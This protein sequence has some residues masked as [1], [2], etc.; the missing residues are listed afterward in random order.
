[1]SEAEL[2]VFLV[3]D[4]EDIRRTL[5][6]A[7]KRR[8]FEVEA[9]ASAQEFLDAFEPDRPGCLVLDYGMPGMTGL[10][11]QDHLNEAG[12]TIP[13]I[14]ITG[15][16]G[17]PESVRAIR[18][19][20]VDFLEKPFR[21]S[22]LIEQIQAA[23]DMSLAQ[24]QESGDRAAA[25]QRFDRLT[26]REREIA[27]ILVTQPSDASSKHIARALD[28]SPRTV[29]HHR[30]RILEKMDVRSVAELVHLANKSELFAK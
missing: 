18:S 1:M 28:I 24:S 3:D 19:G 23:F 30:A 17:V 9:F 8:G 12:A 10:E 22:V 16:G 5:S 15:H 27:Q 14:F 21:Q 6:R 13:I 25:A 7:L 4:D 2:T 29:D 26:I 11:L 20:A